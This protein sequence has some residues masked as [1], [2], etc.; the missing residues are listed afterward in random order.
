MENFGAPIRTIENVVALVGEDQA[1]WA[2]HWQTIFQ[3]AAS[4]MLEIAGD[5]PLLTLR[6]GDCSSRCGPFC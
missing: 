5:L 2:R 6:R 1:R 3:T 4:S